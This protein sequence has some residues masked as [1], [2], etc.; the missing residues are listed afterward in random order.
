MADPLEKIR[1][2]IKDRKQFLEFLSVPSLFLDGDY[3]TNSWLIWEFLGDFFNVTFGAVK[4]DGF[5][6]SLLGQDVSISAG[7]IWYKYFYIKEDGSTSLNNL[8]VIGTDQYIYLK[9][10]HKRITIADDP[11]G[12]TPITIRQNINGVDNSRPNQYIYDS[13]IIISSDSALVDVVGNI[14]DD[15]LGNPSIG[16]TYY[17]RLAH[18]DASEAVTQDIPL[19]S[20]VASEAQI[21]DLQSQIDALII[22]IANNVDDIASV[23]GQA[24][25][26]SSNIS[27][28]QSQDNAK[29]FT[30]ANIFAKTQT[31]N[32]TNTE[33]FIEATGKLVLST[34]HAGNWF[35]F[36][37]SSAVTLNEVGTLGT[38]TSVKI[39]QTGV[40]TITVV[41]T[42]SKIVLP[43]ATN[44]LL[45]DGDWIELLE[46]GPGKWELVGN[47]SN[48]TRRMITAEFE[49]AA[50][51]RSGIAPVGSIFPYWR[52]WDSNP[53]DPDTGF[54]LC[55]GS[56]VNHSLSP[57]NTMSTPD[58]R[59]LVIVGAKSDS[60]NP[61]NNLQYD[62]NNI[63]PAT[64]G[65]ETQS[66]LVYDILSW[67]EKIK[68]NIPG[69]PA[70]SHTVR[71]DDGGS[72]ATSAND[73]STS[74]SPPTMNSGISGGNEAVENRMPYC[75][76]YYIMRIF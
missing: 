62:L 6:V 25:T 45:V 30:A 22:D 41:H 59:G 21:D 46:T 38:G 5:I 2:S 36:S 54:Q 17:L 61:N 58:L 35:I 53:I 32:L 60:S 3:N 27:V 31:Y 70:H 7:T 42:A 65:A 9:I 52:S 10:S 57:F 44:L 55:D 66:T 75:A 68:T 47:S 20:T 12:T 43:G 73:S 26:N 29:L 18:I 72:V 33:G 48:L 69:M 39:R 40:G 37:N 23:Q 71:M 34:T 74:T 19:F 49:I 4:S 14:P 8:R 16:D 13:E 63:G 76:L 50:L 15:G 24:D 28:L 56:V 67:G 11:S 1:Y 51:E 64:S